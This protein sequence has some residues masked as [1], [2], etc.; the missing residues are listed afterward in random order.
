MDTNTQAV[1]RGEA[2]GVIFNFQLDFQCNGN[3]HFYIWRH[4]PLDGTPRENV[5]LLIDLNG[6]YVPGFEIDKMV[7]SLLVPATGIVS[8]AFVNCHF[9]NHQD[10]KRKLKAGNVRLYSNTA[11]F[12][13]IG[14]ARQW[15]E[16]QSASC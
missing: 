10:I 5:G 12:A 1:Q 15:L 7:C 14:Q 9:H 13:D 16:S 2:Q 3:K 8:V 6:V 11:F 4:H